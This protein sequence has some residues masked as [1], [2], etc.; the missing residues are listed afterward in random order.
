MKKTPK[1]K[2]RALAR[3]Q[4]F[5][6]K[7]QESSE[8]NF[9]DFLASMRS[10]KTRKSVSKAKRARSSL[11]WAKRIAVKRTSEYKTMAIYVSD[12]NSYFF[13]VLSINSFA[14]T[15]EISVL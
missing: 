3:R 5:G 6:G 7:D 9:S 12:I 4:I 2:A 14:F 15:T 13:E 11:N 8:E 10:D 1:V